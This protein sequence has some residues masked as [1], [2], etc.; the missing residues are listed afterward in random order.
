MSTCIVSAN[1][2]NKKQKFDT[3][4]AFCSY[5]NKST[6][7]WCKSIDWFLHEL[8]SGHDGFKSKSEKSSYDEKK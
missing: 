5:R 2:K 1:I 6:D 8:N 7:L 4:K 3:R